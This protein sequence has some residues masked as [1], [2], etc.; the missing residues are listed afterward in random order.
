L[1][2]VRRK[3]FGKPN[4]YAID[5]KREEYYKLDAKIY[6]CENDVARDDSEYDYWQRKA[7]S[8]R[9]DQEKIK[10]WFEKYGISY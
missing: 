2:E 5:A 1:E 4:E 9:K 7:Q 8:M 3:M 6:S 10:R